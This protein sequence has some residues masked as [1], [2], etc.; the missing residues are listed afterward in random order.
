MHKE[1]ALDLRVMEREINHALREDVVVESDGIDLELEDL[2][3]TWIVEN[4]GACIYKGI[5]SYM[6]A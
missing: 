3:L 4:T 6:F 2:E 1:I 5:I